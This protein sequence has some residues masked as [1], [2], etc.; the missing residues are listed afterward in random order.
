[1]T[2]YGYDPVTHMHENKATICRIEAA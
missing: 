2:T 1:V